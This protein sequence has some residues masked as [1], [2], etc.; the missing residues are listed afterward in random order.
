V[1]VLHRLAVAGYWTFPV[2][3][4]LRLDRWAELPEF[5]SEAA[6]RQLDLMVAVL[7]R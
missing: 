7:A 4:R 5:E 1:P 2:E 6:E 3:L